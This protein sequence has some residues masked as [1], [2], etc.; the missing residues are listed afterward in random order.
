MKTG[1]STASECC[2]TLVSWHP[3]ILP[4]KK[5]LDPSV[6]PSAVAENE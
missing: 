4:S 2:L 3:R 6:V 1:K 5:L